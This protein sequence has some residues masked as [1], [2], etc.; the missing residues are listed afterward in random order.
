[1]VAMTLHHFIAGA[2]DVAVTFACAGALLWPV[3]HWIRKEIKK[4]P[5]HGMRW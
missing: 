2:I 4:H 5:I 3:I 1:M